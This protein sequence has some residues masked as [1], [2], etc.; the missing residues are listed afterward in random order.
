MQPYA[1]LIGHI[2]GN[3]DTIVPHPQEAVPIRAV[4]ADV[5][6]LRS[7]VG[8]GVAHGFLGDAKQVCLDL[9]AKPVKGPDK[10]QGTPPRGGLR[11]VK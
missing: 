9:G 2:L 11:V 5:D 6:A 10:P 3:A 1:V 8:Y 7:S 4:Q